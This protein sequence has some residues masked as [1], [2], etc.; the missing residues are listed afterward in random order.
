VVVVVVVPVVAVLVDCL[1]RKSMY[2]QVNLPSRLP[3]AQVVGM[4]LA[5]ACSIPSAVVDKARTAV[6]VAVAE[7]TAVQ[8]QAVVVCRVLE[9]TARP[10]LCAAGVVRVPHHR[11]QTAGQVT[12]LQHSSVAQQ[13][14]LLV[15]AV[16]RTAVWVSMA[17]AM[18]EPSTTPDRTPPS[19]PAEAAGV[20]VNP[21]LVLLVA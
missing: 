2:P 14:W 18:V 11:V 16:E 10:A 1:L 7:P 20:A 19:I 17:V 8:A 13:A 9:T 4:P 12:T 21:A 3:S 15:A 5:L 6:P